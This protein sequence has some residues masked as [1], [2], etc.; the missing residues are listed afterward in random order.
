MV[1][2]P[3]LLQTAPTIE[4]ANICEIL[5]IDESRASDG[6]R[7]ERMSHF[8]EN[9]SIVNGRYTASLMASLL[10]GTPLDATALLHRRY[11]RQLSD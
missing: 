9:F 8:Q 1:F 2:D 6:A 3:F 11:G 7:F 10:A 5:L 4:D